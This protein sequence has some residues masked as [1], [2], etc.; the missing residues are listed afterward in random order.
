VDPGRLTFCTQILG[1]P[2][3]RLADPAFDMLAHL[4]FT[5]AQ[6][7]AAN[8]HVCGAMTLEGAPHPE[9][10]ASGGLRLRQSLRQEGQAATCRS[11]ATSG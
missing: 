5:R 2:E 4:G 10:R 8:D 1:I 9:A 6:I 3:E 11:K 7:D